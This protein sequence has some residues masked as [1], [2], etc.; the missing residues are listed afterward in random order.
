MSYSVKG[1]HH[2]T[3]IASDAQ[4]NL[5]FYANELGLR[6]VKKTV[7]FDD[8]GTYHLYYGDGLGTPGSALTFF[9][10]AQLPQGRTGT[11]EA[12]ITLFSVPPGSLDY[13]N[14]RLSASAGQVISA[15]EQ[16][17]QKVL[18]AKDHDGLA[19]ALVENDSDDR[20]P[21]TGNGVDTDAA[22]RG[23]E[24]VTLTLADKTGT[25]D[26]LTGFLDYEEVGTEGP[27]TRYRSKNSDTAAVVDIE[28]HED[29]AAAA[30]GAG[31]VHHVA[32]RLDNRAEQKKLREALMENQVQV[33]P[34]IDRNYFWSI[35]FRSPGGVLFEAA[36]D[37]PGFTADEAEEM[38]GHAL[39]LP[40]Q[41]EA[42]R[43]EIEKILPPLEA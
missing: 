21:W 7:N 29:G 3:A 24:G 4:A 2:V 42:R 14:Q 40:P 35:Y 12:G 30:Q 18:L 22:I 26:W 20:E 32:F 15:G 43:A 28:V 1:L 33:T 37:E 36:T 34:V 39:K 25:A 27:I 38:L 41:Y 31:S 19:F 17:G 10:W 8:P 6:F 11:G 23:F 16:F 13:W 5:D 9:P